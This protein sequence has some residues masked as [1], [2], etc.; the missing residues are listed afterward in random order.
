VEGLREGIWV[1]VY[2]EAARTVPPADADERGVPPI[3]LINMELI[4]DAGWFSQSN[5][6]ATK[7]NSFFIKRLRQYVTKVPVLVGPILA[8]L[9]LAS[10]WTVPDG[11]QLPLADRTGRKKSGRRS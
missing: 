11:L 7:Y 3:S 4:S 10:A 2:F 5:L 1:F 6:W 8:R 9:V